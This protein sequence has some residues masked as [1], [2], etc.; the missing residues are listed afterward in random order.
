MWVAFMGLCNGLCKLGK[1]KNSAADLRE[2]PFFPTF[3]REYFFTEV[4]PREGG[5]EKLHQAFHPKLGD[6]MFILNIFI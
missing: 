6:A 3:D 2:H 4:D 5:G 1:K